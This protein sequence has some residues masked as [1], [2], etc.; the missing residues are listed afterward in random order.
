MSPGAFSFV[1]MPLGASDLLRLER[2]LPAAD[3][4]LQSERTSR[5]MLP[6]V[7]LHCSAALASTAELGARDWT[8]SHMCGDMKQIKIQQLETITVDCE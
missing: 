6:C 5:N 2:L 8:G 7:D 1:S 4:S 3:I